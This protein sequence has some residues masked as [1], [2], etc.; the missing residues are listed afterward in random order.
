MD[1]I[2][3]ILEA[4][5]VDDMFDILVA[6]FQHNRPKT[7]FIVKSPTSANNIDSS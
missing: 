3:I 4:H 6:D 2:E 1:S 7:V 5:Y